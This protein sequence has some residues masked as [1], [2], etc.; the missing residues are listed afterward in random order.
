MPKFRFCLVCLATLF[1]FSD[2]FAQD[3]IR[4]RRPKP[5]EDPLSYFIYPIAYSVPGVGQGT[6]A[7]ATLVYEEFSSTFFSVRGPWDLDALILKDIPLSTWNFT[8]SLAATQI[9]GGAFVFYGRGPDSGSNPLATVNL[10]DSTLFAGEF[11][12]YALDRQ[13]NVYAGASAN[14]FRVSSVTEKEIGSYEDALEQKE[15]QYSVLNVFKPVIGRIGFTWDNTDNESDPH[16]GFR[17]NYEKFRQLALG[18]FF[19]FDIDNFEYSHYLPVFNDDVLVWNLF[20]SQSTGS[21]KNGRKLVED[22]YQSPI[23]IAACLQEIAEGSHDEYDDSS[24]LTPEE[25]CTLDNVALDNFLR[26]GINDPIGSTP[27]GGT[28]R[29]RSYP[30]GR[31]YDTFSFSTSLEYR[32]YFLKKDSVPFDFIL[33]KGAYEATQVAFFLDMGNVAPETSELTDKL[34]YSAGTGIRLILGGTVL[35]FDV[36][37]GDEGTEFIAF[38]GHPF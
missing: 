11:N 34:K 15:F 38:F 8:A 19:K 31:F 24:V 2:A 10:E 18:D 29:L 17:F 12:Y 6:G 20:Y 30:I 36:A 14:V 5:S 16:D 26:S 28:N 7:G 35:R 4:K 9:K 33:E 37:T 21:K 22:T 13:I 25:F 3:F 1:L 32:A 27:L 23:E